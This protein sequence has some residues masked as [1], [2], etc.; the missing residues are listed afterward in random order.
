MTTERL[1]A[2]LRQLQFVSREVIDQ[3]FIQHQQTRGGITA[4]Q[5]VEWLRQ[6]QYITDDQGQRL[7]GMDSEAERRAADEEEL[8]LAPI[9]DEPRQVAKPIPKASAPA[10]QP[11]PPQRW[12]GNQAQ[13]P[14]AGSDDLLGALL[15]DPDLNSLS[16]P[17]AAPPPVAKGLPK[18]KIAGR[19]GWDTPLVMVGVGALTLLLIVGGVLLFAV[20]RQ[21]GD[22]AFALAEDDYRNG[23]YGQSIHKYN[24]YLEEYPDHQSASLARVHCGLAQLRQTV[25]GSPRWPAALTTA[26]EVLSQIAGEREFGTAQSE[27]AAVLPDIA[28]GLAKQA[29]EQPDPASISLARD[30]VGLVEKYVSKARRPEQQLHDVDATIA[31]AQ[32][33][34]DRDKNL[35]AAIEEIQTFVANGAA[36]QAYA[37]RKRL[38]ASYPDA[39]S[40]KQLRTAMISVAEAERSGIKFLDARR[41]AAHN[42]PATD[43]DASVTLVRETPVNIPEPLRQAVF[44]LA[45]G[46]AYGLDSGRGRVLWRRFVGFDTLT[47]PLRIATLTGVDALLLDSVRNEIVRV[48]GATGQLRWRQ[49]IS[50]PLDAIPALLRYPS[51]TLLVARRSGEI[52]RVAADSGESLGHVKMPVGLRMGPVLDARQH[53]AYQLGEHSSL[54]VL[55][56]DDLSC[57]EIVY[58]GH[59]PQTIT[60]PPLVIN[61]YVVVAHNHSSRASK[62]CVYLGNDE[63][64]ELKLQQEQTLD[65]QV[66]S[67]LQV[68]GRSLLVATTAGKLYAFELAAPGQGTPLAKTAEAKI[69]DSESS[70]GF[71][72]N[73]GAEVWLGWNGLAKYE[74]QAARGTFEQR[75]WQAAGETALQPAQLAGQIVIGVRS[76]TGT[77]SVVVEAM[78]EDGKRLWETVLG[79]PLAGGPLPLSSN[80]I[81]GLDLGG[82]WF[83]VDG[84]DFGQGVKLPTAQQEGERFAQHESAAA[85]GRDQFVYRPIAQGKDLPALRLTVVERAGAPERLRS[86][87]IPEPAAIPPMAWMGG[88]VFPAKIGQVV[89]L[90]VGTGRRLAAPFSPRIEPGVEF[91][92]TPPALIGEREIVIADGRLK[93]YRLGLVD[94][95]VSHLE[96]LAECVLTEPV[97]SPLAALTKVVYGVTA[98]GRLLTYHLPDLTVGPD[99][100]LG[101]SLAWGPQRVGDR[102]LLATAAG[103]LWCLDDQ[104][105]L[106]W[107]ASLAHGS[108]AGPPLETTGG[109]IVAASTGTV[110]RIAVDSGQELGRVEVGEPLASGP[111]LSGDRLVVAGHDGTLHRVRVP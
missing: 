87:E 6:R 36:Q 103:E 42:E 29:N 33:K 71:L 45:R 111:L 81:G 35:A 43:R 52:E 59:E 9:D 63:G 32:H 67:P 96:A 8:G 73:R 84:Q 53:S 40:D 70:V 12:S 86:I 90:D 11:E 94:K 48:D 1:L 108:L 104:E 61:R 24:L 100:E 77:S 72:T 76:R 83:E 16:D 28:L 64:L 107:K 21:S 91:P 47:P 30:A 44:T 25:E 2:A 85:V 4:E 69:G 101:S 93:I 66:R 102:V 27:L 62:L 51:E 105:Q 106:V 80:R 97:S 110:Y 37:V 89:L 18:P 79:T 74:L 56:V 50:E 26:R 38:L 78:K 98:S 109:W 75:W 23:L 55:K 57:R 5:C 13:M 82:C 54:F 60:V 99:R 3:L 39:A 7:L 46:A 14:T 92:W 31:L 20:D 95:P 49:T 88:V 58:L 10:I 34:L 22:K 68:S 65:G 15:N 41:Q 19:T 17:L